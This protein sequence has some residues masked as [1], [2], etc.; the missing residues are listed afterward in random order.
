[1]SLA[2]QGVQLAHFSVDVQQDD[3]RRQQGFSRGQGGRRRVRGEASGEDDE[4]ANAVF[5]VDLNQ[6]L[7]HWVA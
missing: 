6:G 3:G 5:R 4:A 7:L 2:Q 1:M